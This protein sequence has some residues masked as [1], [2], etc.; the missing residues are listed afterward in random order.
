MTNRPSWDN[1]FMTIA[2]EVSKRSTCLRRQV[3]AIVVKD[4]QYTEIGYNGAPSHTRHCTDIGYCLR[5]KLNIPSGQRHEVC[6]GAHGDGNAIA[7]AGKEK[8]QGATL[9]IYGGTPCGYCA[10][11]AINNGISRIV[12]CGD[13]PDDLALELLREANVVVEKMQIAK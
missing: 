3:G 8:C 5:D 6:R 10:K 13:Y 9:Y 12:C 1:T 2:K 4:N 7:R 11:L